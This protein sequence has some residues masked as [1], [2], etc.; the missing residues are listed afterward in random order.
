MANLLLLSG[1]ELISY[2]FS[3]NFVF[4]YRL[5]RT[6]EIEVHFEGYVKIEAIAIEMKGRQNRNETPS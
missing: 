4:G 5:K 6:N 3:L 2:Y 1:S